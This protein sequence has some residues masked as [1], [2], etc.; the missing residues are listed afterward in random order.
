MRYSVIGDWDG[1]RYV[2]WF[3]S[4]SSDAA[5]DLM[6]MKA[7]E[8]GGLFWVCAVLRGWAKAADT[9]AYYVDKDDPRHGERDDLRP[10]TSE[11]EI[12]EWTVVGRVVSRRAGGWN[13][14]TGGERFIGYEMAFAPDEAEDVAH[15]R[16]ADKPDGLLKVATVLPG[17]VLRE[18]SHVF[19]NRHERASR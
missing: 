8:E 7:S 17:H 13:Q 4:V 18:D 12:T 10:A 9:Y 15:S 5:E 3:D 11:L 19:C 6:L 2:E 14:R 1:E 16:V